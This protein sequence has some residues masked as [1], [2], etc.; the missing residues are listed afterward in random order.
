MSQAPGNDTVG[1]GD[2]ERVMFTSGGQ[3]LAG[4]LFPA[5]FGSGPAPAVAVIGPETYVKEQSP[6]QY[7]WRMARNGYTALIFD[8]RYWGE[9]GGQPRCAEDPEA[10]VEDLRAA[11]A[12]LAARP[13]VTQSSWR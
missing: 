12:F 8:A 13:E 6:L 3:T 4:R 5:A 2:G 7:A 10:K 1:A 11:V 9:S